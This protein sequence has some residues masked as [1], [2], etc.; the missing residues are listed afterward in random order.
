M[1][2]VKLTVSLPEEVVDYL[3]STPNMSSTI[4]EAVTEYQARRLEA[5]LEQAY[6]EDAAEAEELNREWENVDAE[7]SE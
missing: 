5:E 4:A 6:R 7:P 2:R 3:R 1:A